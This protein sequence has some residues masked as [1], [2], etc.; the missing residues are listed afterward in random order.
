MA[1]NV[2]L[3]SLGLSSTKRISGR[4]SS[5]IGS[6]RREVEGC[7]PVD[8]RF[9]PDTSGMTL[10]DAL[11]DGQAHAGAFEILGAVQPLEDAEQLVGV[12][13]V[14]AGAIVADKADMCA[15]NL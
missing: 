7:A 10:Y 3:T 4:R 8:G 11:C 14:E 5:M 15:A 6:L 12:L 9:G 2:S 13:H 1:C